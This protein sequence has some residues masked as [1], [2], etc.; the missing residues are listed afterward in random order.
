MLRR[1]VIMRNETFQGTWFYDN[2]FHQTLL[3]DLASIQ[4]ANPWI[5]SIDGISHV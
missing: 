3:A 4:P 2:N 5:D 1:R